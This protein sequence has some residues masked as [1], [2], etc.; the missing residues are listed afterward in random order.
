MIYQIVFLFIYLF[1][2]IYGFH[3]EKKVFLKFISWNK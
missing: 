2:I 3:F 1:N